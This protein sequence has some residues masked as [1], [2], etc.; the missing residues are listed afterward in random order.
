MAIRDTVAEYLLPAC[1]FQR[2]LRSAKV[3]PELAGLKIP[4]APFAVP[5]AGDFMTPPYHLSYKVGTS[6]RRPAHHKGR[7]VAVEPVE[8]VQ[9]SQNAFIKA[10]LEVRPAAAID[11]VRERH[12]LEIV[13]QGH[14]HDVRLRWA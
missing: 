7:R 9:R 1:S 11:Y 13:L 5:G 8:H 3:I 14:S 6:F 10:G 12:T 2:R 4:E